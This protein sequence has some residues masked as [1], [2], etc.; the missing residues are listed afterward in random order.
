MGKAIREADHTE[1]NLIRME[2][3]EADSLTAT[4]ADCMARQKKLKVEQVAVIKKDGECLAAIETAKQAQVEQNVAEETVEAN[5][6][7]TENNLEE[8]SQEELL[9]S[10]QN[11]QAECQAA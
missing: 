7:A 2:K 5:C 4:D 10:I 6:I 1:D 11:L 9:N 3:F 8:D